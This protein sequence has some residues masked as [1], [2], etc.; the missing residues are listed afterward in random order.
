MHVATGVRGLTI[1]EAEQVFFEASQKI[2]QDL[3]IT[4]QL[5]R[6]TSGP[7]LYDSDFS[8]RIASLNNWVRYM[9]RNGIKPRKKTI[10]VVITPP[11]LHQGNYYIAGYS[12]GT[13][14]AGRRHSVVVVNLQ[15][16]NQFGQ[17]RWSQSVA[18]LTH[19]LSHAL[20]A[21]HVASATMMNAD[22][23]SYVQPPQL[24]PFALVS[25][26]AIRYCQGLPF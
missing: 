3:G 20:G 22:V 13:C 11:I 10:H 26:N 24:P 7:N 14:T 18:A 9:R 5:S 16:E 15:K 25:Y 8:G 19:E 21:S 23:M 4:L 2:Q 1:S 12:K 17:D 6:L